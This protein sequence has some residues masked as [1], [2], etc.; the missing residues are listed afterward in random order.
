MRAPDG[1]ARMSGGRLFSHPGNML[2]VVMSAMI[3]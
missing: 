1:E 2:A 3:V